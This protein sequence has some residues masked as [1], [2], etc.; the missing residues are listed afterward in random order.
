MEAGAVPRMV[1]TGVPAFSSPRFLRVASDARLVGLIREGRTAA[2]EAAYDRHHRGIL[3][4][5]RHMLGDA[6]E[7][8]DAVQYTFMAA[9]NDLMAS[10]KPI[11]LRAWLFTIARNRCYSILRSRREQPSAELE[12]PVTEGLAAQVQRRQ[13]LRDLIVDLRRLPDDQRAALVLAELDALSHNE[14]SDVLGVPREKVKA[15]VFQARESL[16]ATRTA[17]ETA[18]TD[19]R[20]QISAGC[21]GTL[22]RSNLRRHLRDCEGCREFRSQVERQRKQIAVLLPVLPT[23]ALKELILGAAVGAGGAGVIGGGLAASALKSG[24][25]KAVLGGLL[26]GAGTAGTFVAAGELPLNDVIPLFSK[27]PAHVRASGGDGSASRNALGV[28]PASAAAVTAGGPSSLAA[29]TPALGS[30][31]SASPLLFT[32]RAG[33]VV[34]GSVGRT[35]V[36]VHV[37]RPRHARAPAPASTPVVVA[38]KPVS[39]PVAVT[40]VITATPTDNG[41]IYPTWHSGSGGHGNSSSGGGRRGGSTSSWSGAGA[42][43]DQGAGG[44]SGS[45]HHGSGSSQGGNGASG[46]GSGGGSG[47]SSGGG[48]RGGGG[49]AGGSGGG[50]GSGSGSGSG[51]GAGA[52]AGGSGGGN[53]S[54]GTR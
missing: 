22:R 45:A 35:R 43:R 39:H 38:P 25:A 37:Q 33:G 28:D 30:A 14:I 24:L 54:G 41:P 20:A 32:S 11:H 53:G 19:I 40:P 47:G 15:L 44:G 48:S 31:P 7:A 1:P 52:G 50:A 9:Y 21:G 51:A 2:F 34:S 36:S 3:S 46:R 5:C 16:I 8:E 18:C 4:F 29:I 6:D 49:G 27:P 13:D 10:E 17:R 23:I 26:A 42:G 12:E